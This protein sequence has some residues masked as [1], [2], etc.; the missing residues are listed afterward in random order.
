MCTAQGR[1]GVPASEVDHI[2]PVR[3][4]AR[5]FWFGALQSL[6]PSCHSGRKRHLEER[7]FDDSI[8]PDGFPIDPK[9]P[10]FTGKSP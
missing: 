6:C 3:G 9:H 5:A 8:G 10:F 4:N 2:V 7:G 1:I